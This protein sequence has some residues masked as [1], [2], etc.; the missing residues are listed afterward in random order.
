VDVVAFTSGSTVHAL[1]DAL[2]EQRELLNGVIVACIGPITARAARE[3][4]LPVHIEAEEHTV[5]GLIQALVEFFAKGEVQE[6]CH[7]SA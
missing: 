6:P 1:L 3:R 7:K 2:G 4:G 5:D